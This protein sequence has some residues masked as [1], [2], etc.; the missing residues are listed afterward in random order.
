MKEGAPPIE[1]VAIPAGGNGLRTVLTVAVVAASL[2]LAAPTGGGSL[3]AGFSNLTGGAIG[4]STASSIIGAGT[5]VLGMLALNALVPPETADSQSLPRSNV[6]SLTSSRNALPD[7]GSSVPILTGRVRITPP[8]AAR[9]YT[10]L[11]GDNQYVTQLFG[12]GVGSMT[13]TTAK[14]GDT[15]IDDYQDVDTEFHSADFAT[16]PDLNLYRN[17]VSEL[18]VGAAL[19]FASGY[20]TRT[21]LDVCDQLTVEISFPR[22]LIGTSSN[23]KNINERTIDFVIETKK[24]TE[25]TFVVA[26]TFT[27]KRKTSSLVRVAKT[28]TYGSEA[29]RDVRVKRLSPDT[30][31]DRLIDDSFWTILRSTNRGTPPVTEKGISLYAVDIRATD[32]LNG[33]LDQLNLEATTICLDYDGTPGSWTSRATRNPAS[34]FR[35]ILQWPAAER[36]VPDN[37]IDLSML[38]DW[39]DYCASRDL[40]A[41]LYI[42]EPISRWD[43]LRRI[44][45][46]GEAVPHRPDGKWSVAI[47]RAQSEVRQFYTPRNS[48]NFVLNQFY[49]KPPHAIRV[50]FAN[51]LAG[52]QQDEVIAY[53]DGYDS[54]NA[55]LYEA[56]DAPG[57]STAEVAWRRG[58]RRLAEGI[59]RSVEYAFDSDWEHLVVTKGD[60]IRFGHDATLEGVGW[61]RIVSIEENEDQDRWLAVTIDD[62][63]T[64]EPGESYRIIIRR[65]SLEGEERSLVTVVGDTRR[66][67]FLN[68]PLKSATPIVAELGN[69]VLVQMTAPVVEDLIVRG[70][71]P[72]PDM[73]ARL[74]CIPYRTQVYTSDTEDI[75][76]IE[77][78]ITLP[79]GKQVPIITN[80]RADAANARRMPDGSVDVTVEVQ[81]FQAL[82]Q[83][84]LTVDRIQVRWRLANSGA[85]WRKILA[86]GS[87]S[88]VY[89]QANIDEELE[90][91][92]RYIFHDRS[93]AYS[94][95]YFYIVENVGFSPLDVSALFQDDR[96]LRWTLVDPPP[97]LAGFLIR[98]SRDR[99]V[100]WENAI[101]MHDGIWTDQIFEVADLGEQITH[102]YVKAV[103]TAGLESENAAI[104][105]VSR[106]TLDPRLEV[107]REE[108]GPFG[109]G[110][111]IIGGQLTGALGTF[112]VVANSTSIFIPGDDAPFLPG[113]EF[114]DPTDPGPDPEPEPGVR[115]KA[116]PDSYTMQKNGLLSINAFAGL[117]ANDT[118]AL[119]VELIGAAPAGTFLLNESGAFSYQPPADFVGTISFNYVAVSADNLRGPA[120]AVTIIVDDTDDTPP[121][122]HDYGST[123][124]VTAPASPRFIPYFQ[125]GDPV[126]PSEG[127]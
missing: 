121:G 5:S 90:I 28:Y 68:P 110:G 59:H 127:I 53:A 32:Q 77:T 93:G 3:A 13:V 33:A 126:L 40:T 57:V 62:T 83:G 87:D 63:V 9:P 84:A 23:G 101:P 89:F 17:S 38:E 75:G 104:A 30:N 72:G 25:S 41:D 106:T 91:Q 12:L 47:D 48:S 60:R 76:D 7:I 92:A 94:D 115:P 85:A 96:F 55:T 73:S 31:E 49:V 113:G 11:N 100:L 4:V 65:D 52:Y 70:I 61:G 119:S 22:G 118:N 8:Q 29:I 51:Q 102:A 66:L 78:R 1:V 124:P 71:E 54:S 99:N 105:E 95:S 112:I 74:T 97:D 64:M 35:Y 120:T 45:A 81:I 117:L 69:L 36:V 27:I 39:H 79:A 103:T 114:P 116:L 107:R 80:V 18:S 67:E 20:V 16:T 19:T 43:M 14:I 15:S 86:D 56:M 37:R 21:T 50:R 109:F 2:A 125:Q 46:C 123:T 58:R 98:G 42:T 34:L 26:E 108:N 122:T 82:A 24:S 88:S 111:T 6:F 44:A 10:R